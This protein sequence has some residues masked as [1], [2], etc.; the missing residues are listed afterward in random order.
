MWFYKSF[1]FCIAQKQRFPIITELIRGRASALFIEFLR[2]WCCAI[3]D[4]ILCIFIFFFIIALLVA[5]I[6][7]AGSIALFIMFPSSC[8]RAGPKHHMTVV[9]GGVLAHYLWCHPFP[10]CN[11]VWFI[12]CVLHMLVKMYVLHTRAHSVRPCVCPINAHISNHARYKSTHTFAN[13][14]V[15]TSNYS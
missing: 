14:Q 13:W 6:N 10:R 4:S 15:E 7:I 1:H 3:Y 9:H 12:Y 8:Q 11:V 5:F 2:L